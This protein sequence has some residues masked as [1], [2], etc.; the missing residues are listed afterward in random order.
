MYGTVVTLGNRFL[1]VTGNR[2]LDFG[3][4]VRS[5]HRSNSWACC[6][7]EQTLWGAAFSPRISLSLS[8]FGFDFLALQAQKAQIKPAS[9]IIQKTFLFIYTFMFSS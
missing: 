5:A 3:Y 8:A 1:S 6:S 4:A 2:T 7:Y 9:Y